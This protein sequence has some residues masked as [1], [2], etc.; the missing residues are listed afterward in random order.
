MTIIYKELNMDFQ[1]YHQTS[2]GCALSILKDKIFYSCHILSDHGLNGYL[3]RE[4]INGQTLEGRGAELVLQWSGDVEN[5]SI[6]FP[7]QYMKKNTLY[8]QERWR[9]FIPAN[10]DA[11]L[12]KI[13]NVK[14]LNEKKIDEIIRYPTIYK[15]LPL[16]CLQ[17]YLKRKY[18]LKLI[19][20]FR[21]YLNDDRFLK[22]K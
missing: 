18:K 7:V 4:N 13:I 1:F 9:V 6:D 5:V 8:I 12:L 10:L 19:K 11:D 16:N 15:K 22:I 17:K 21:G 2:S 3:K 20:K 14:F